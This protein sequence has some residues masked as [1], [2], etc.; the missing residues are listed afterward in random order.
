[1]KLRQPF[2]TSLQ[3]KQQRMDATIEAMDRLVDYEIADVTAAATYY[4]AETY[5]NFSRSL[6]ES[7]RPTDLKPAD[8]EAFEMDLDEK[9]F[10]F[11]EKAISVHEKNMELLHAGV[12]N[13]WTE[14]SLGRLTEL[15]PGRYAKHE[16]SSGFLARSKREPTAVSRFADVGSADTVHG[17]LA[18]GELKLRTVGIEYASGAHVMHAACGR[19]RSRADLRG[20][21]VTHAG[22]K[23]T[24][25]ARHRPAAQGDRTG[26][27]INA[28]RTSISASHTRA[29]ATWTTPR[30]A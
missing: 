14:K 7:E 23:R 30:P 1:M 2:E 22:E 24:V 27:R 12:F 11:E 10:P 9:A 21:A 6:V 18:S 16:T 28:L 3:D 8:L 19:S 15:M 17:D 25:R 13:A 26:A 29:P 5:F 20:A 4:M